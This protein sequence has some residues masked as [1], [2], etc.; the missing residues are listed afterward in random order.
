MKSV[1]LVH[2]RDLFKTLVAN[3]TH[4]QAGCED[5]QKEKKFYLGPLL[6]ELQPVVV[7]STVN[8]CFANIS[9]AFSTFHAITPCLSNI[10]MAYKGCN[11][12][13]KRSCHTNADIGGISAFWI[14][15]SCFR[16]VIINL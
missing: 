3:S 9:F 6:Q 5:D 1:R 2:P 8:S 14:Q 15:S 10:L 16:M 7:F 13:Y 12:C 4:D 11:T